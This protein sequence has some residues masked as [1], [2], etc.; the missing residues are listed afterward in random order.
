MLFLYLLKCVFSSHLNTK[1]LDL[2]FITYLRYHVTDDAI[3]SLFFLVIDDCELCA[4]VDRFLL[5][6]FS[7]RDVCLCSAGL[8]S[9][10]TNLW[11]TLVIV[12]VIFIVDP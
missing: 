9:T 3:T 7:G 8:Q 12:P 11:S 1:Q 10:N 2:P 4:F 6:G 5:E